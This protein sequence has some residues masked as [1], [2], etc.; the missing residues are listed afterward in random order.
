M[1]DRE[2]GNIGCVVLLREGLLGVAT[3]GD[4]GCQ[5]RAADELE[6]LVLPVLVLLVGEQRQRVPWAAGMEGVGEGVDEHIAVG[7]AELAEEAL[8]A[9]A[10]VADEGAARDPFGRSGVGGDG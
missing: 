9:L 6:E 1:R 10:G 4:D 3:E 5:R 7:E 2:R 8:D